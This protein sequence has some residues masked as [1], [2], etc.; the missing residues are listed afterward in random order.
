MGFWSDVGNGAAAAASTVGNAIEN[1]SDAIIDTVEDVVATV[2]DG[3]AAVPGAINDGAAATGNQVVAGIGAVVAGVAMGF[4]NFVRDVGHSTANIF[5]DV[6]GVLGGTLRGDF[7]YAFTHLVESI[8]DLGNVLLAFGRLVTGGYFVGAIEV[9]RKRNEL[10]AFVED[11]LASTFGG[12]ASRLSMIRSHVGL[13]GGTWG[14]PMRATHRRFML[15][16]ATMDAGA[17]PLWSLHA[18]GTID[19][20]AL[21]GLWSSDQMRNSFRVWPHATPTSVVYMVG[22]DGTEGMRADRFFLSRYIN[23][24]KHPGRIRIY[25]MSRSAVAERL[26]VASDKC[27]GLGVNLIW[28][29]GERFSWMRG[30]ASFEITTPEEIFF[31]IN[32]RSAANGDISLDRPGSWLIAKGLR[33]RV[34]RTVSEAADAK[35][36]DGMPVAFAVFQYNARNATNY[37]FTAGRAIAQGASALPCATAGRTDACCSRIARMTVPVVPTPPPTPPLPAAPLGSG[38]FHRDFWPNTGARYIL[39]HELGHY[40]GLCHVGHS[41]LDNIMFSPDPRVGLVPI[42][43][44]MFLSYWAWSEPKFTLEDCKNAWRFLVNQMPH[45]L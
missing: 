41:G 31:S 11:L 37:G 12:D 23:D 15:D 18:A 28:N 32:Q 2:G 35:A 40:L 39:A 30:Y 16:S 19:L 29:D 45:I 43:A 10:R 25:A 9:Y 26:Q 22:D 36:E 21:A 8:L 7:G 13:T 20:Y 3:I 24:L 17:T 34:D 14:L 6:A 44:G 1:G 4:V 33:S 42:T 38:V 27:E 5:R